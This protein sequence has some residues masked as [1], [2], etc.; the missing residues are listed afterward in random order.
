M[1]VR[2]ITQ[3]WDKSA[4]SGTDLLMLLALADYSDDEGNSYPAVASLAR[5]CR[6]K[7]RNANYVIKALQVSG[8]LRV[9]QNEGPRGTNRYRI[10]LA[11]LGAVKPLQRVAPLQSLA[12]LQHSAPTPAMHGCLPLQP[13]ADEPSLNR[14][15]PSPSKTASIGFDV[16]YKAYPRKV[17]KEAA[18][19]AFAKAKAIASLD[20]ILADIDRRVS[21]G[22]W[23]A[24]K[25]Q[26]IPHPATYLNGKRWEDEQY[27]GNSSAM[28]GILPGA[29]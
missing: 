14:Q 29:I 19:K 16:F 10:M 28:G 7:T 25:S 1:S 17:G 22:E 23:T 4:H 21:G 20:N 3:V 26:Y 8:E 11:Q 18:G 12:P 15:E 13:I 2:C 5:K 24:E 9:L 27:A 6:M